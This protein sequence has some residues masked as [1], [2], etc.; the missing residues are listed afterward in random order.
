MDRKQLNGQDSHENHDLVLQSR[1]PHGLRVHQDVMAPPPTE[2]D[3]FTIILQYVRLL[4]KRKWVLVF[5]CLIGAMAATGLTLNE[6][7]MYVS[8]VSMQIDNLQEPFGTRLIASSPALQTQIQVMLSQN[9][10]GRA[11]SKLRS[12]PPSEPPEV[13][14]PLA[15]LRKMLGM[16]QPIES[17]TWGQAVGMA[18]GSTRINDP[19]ESS[20][21]LI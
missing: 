1:Q 14:D 12:K 4:W 13:F 16:K 19:K 5:T 20:L 11:S 18:A 7:P 2:S 3:D 15:G 10:K 17:I 21:L 8:S 9:L 6:M